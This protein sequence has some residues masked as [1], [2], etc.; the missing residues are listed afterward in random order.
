VCISRISPQSGNK[1]FGAT[2]RKI[3]NPKK[4]P[5]KYWGCGEERLLGDFPHRQENS[6]RFYNIQESTTF[7]DVA[8]SMPQIDAALD[9]KQFDHQ[10]SMVDMKG[11]ITNHL[12]SILIDPGSN[13]SYVAPQT[14]EKCK[15]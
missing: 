9:N 14:I 4:E 11:M 12:V 10:A 2:S 7:N 8:R 15:L 1:P 6:R 3:E 5:L 13:L